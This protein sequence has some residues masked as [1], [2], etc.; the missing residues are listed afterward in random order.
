MQNGKKSTV[1]TKKTIIKE[2]A[3]AKSLT[4]WQKLLMYTGGISLV[5]ITGW[6]VNRLYLKKIY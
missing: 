5:I 1:P 2:V 3:V 6:L 4:F